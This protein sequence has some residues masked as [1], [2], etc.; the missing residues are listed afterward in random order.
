[1][2]LDRSKLSRARPGHGQ[3]GMKLA[4]VIDQA[5]A[6]RGDRAAYDSWNTGRVC[7]ILLAPEIAVDGRDRKSYY[8]LTSV[9]WHG[10]IV[11]EQA[12][13]NS[14][15]VDVLIQLMLMH[16]WQPE[17]Y[18]ESVCRVRGNLL[19]RRNVHALSRRWI[20]RQEAMVG[21]GRLQSAR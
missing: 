13:M 20:H 2:G 11:V 15:D 12:Y 7:S 10:G 17:R 14:I 3:N 9:G 5:S 16:Y 6:Y 1:L 18:V 4:R 19:S 8:C 21:P